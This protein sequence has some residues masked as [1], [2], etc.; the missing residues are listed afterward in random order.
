MFKGKIKKL[1]LKDYYECNNIYDM[2]KFPYTEKFRR[3]I[4]EGNRVTYVYEKGSKFIGEISYVLDMNDPDYTIESKRVYISRL[5][6]KKEWRRKGIG[7]ELVDFILGTVKKLGYEE[8]SI[9]VDKDNTA[10]LELYRKKG[11][12]TVLFDG[13]DEDGEYYKLLK[14]L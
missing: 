1:D 11:F 6:V 2:K 14:I 10:A 8:A 4:E 7:S 13:A 3:Q 9:G 12:T 5:L